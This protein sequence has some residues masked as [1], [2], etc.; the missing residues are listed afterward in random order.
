[1]GKVKLIWDFRGPNGKRTAEHH[2]VHLHDFI[3]MEKLHGEAIKVVEFSEMHAAATMIIKEE[4][5]TV[6]REKLKPH[7]GQRV[8]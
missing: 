4:D 6:M 1:M 2:C 8:E 5:V 3:K 7:R